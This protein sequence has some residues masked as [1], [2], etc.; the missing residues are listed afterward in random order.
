MNLAGHHVGLACRDGMFLDRRRVEKNNCA[1]W[2]AQQRLLMNRSISAAV[3]E[4]N[5]VQILS[6]GLAYD[7]SAISFYKKT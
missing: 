2:K 6:E 4:N 5:G 1:N 3:F 7:C